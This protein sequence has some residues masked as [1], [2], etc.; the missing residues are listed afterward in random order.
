MFLHHKRTFEKM[1]S[2]APKLYSIMKPYAMRSPCRATCTR[3]ILA[4][5]T[6]PT[7]LISRSDE[8]AASPRSAGAGENTHDNRTRLLHPLYVLAATIGCWGGKIVSVFPLYYSSC[9]SE[10]ESMAR[11]VCA[12]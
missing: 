11:V 3:Y 12:D 5:H 1:G 9:M 8:R 2:H 4:A 6:G 10:I 7:A